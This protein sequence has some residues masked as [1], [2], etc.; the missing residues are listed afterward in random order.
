MKQTLSIKENRDF[1]R[2]YHRGKSAAT[3]YLVVYAA[4]NHSDSNRIGLTVSTKLGCAAVRNRSKRLLREAYRLHEYEIQTGYDFILVARFRTTK[5]KC[6]EVQKQL[7]K[8]IRELNLVC[9]GKKS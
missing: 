5:A 1:R 8:A 4:K 2:L 6:G 3:P 9:Q 7:M